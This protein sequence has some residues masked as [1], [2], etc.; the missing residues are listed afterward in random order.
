MLTALKNKV[1]VLMIG[2]QK[3]TKFLSVFLLSAFGVFVISSAAFAGTSVIATLVSEIL[4]VIVGWMGKLILLLFDLLVGRLAPY[5]DFVDSNAVST[6]W[7]LT[8]DISNMFFILILLAVAFGTILKIEQL[9]Y[10]KVLPKLLV[11]AVVINFSK[12]ICGLIIDFGQVVMLTFVNAFSAAAG[13]NFLNAF[14]LKRLL[15]ISISGAENLGTNLDWHVASAYLLAVVMMTVVLIVV[16]VFIITLAYRIVILWVLVIL[17]PLAFLAGGFPVGKASGAYSKWWEDFVGA[18][19]IGPVLAFF[20]WLAL[21]VA[22]GGNLAEAEFKEPAG[23][24][25][26]VSELTGAGALETAVGGGEN[27][28]MTEGGT[29][30]SVTSF[31]IATA[32]LLAGLTAAQSVGGVAGS[33]AGQATSGVK[34]FMGTALKGT[35][36]GAG[37]LAARAGKGA[38]GWT[39]RQTRAR[40]RL[41]GAVSRVPGM[42]KFGTDRLAGLRGQRAKGVREAAEKAR[43]LS[44]EEIQRRI[45]APALT[46]SQKEEKRALRQQVFTPGF[47][48]HLSAQGMDDNQI[49]DVQRREF[50][51]LEAE[52]RTAGDFDTMKFVGDLK[53]KSP[54]LQT[55]PD[56]RRK[57]GKELSHEDLK[58]VSLDSFKD[59]DFLRGIAERGD[60]EAGGIAKRLGGDRGKNIMQFL[61]DKP[62]GSGV[63]TADKGFKAAT[64]EAG[65]VFGKKAAA[66]LNESLVSQRNAKVDFF[67]NDGTTQKR[68]PVTGQSAR[69]FNDEVL[70][71]SMK[72]QS[73]GGN[74]NQAFG[75][76]AKQG[77]FLNDTYSAS[78]GEALKNAS[79]GASGPIKE[80]GPLD[81]GQTEAGRFYLGIDTDALKAKGKDPE[82]GNQYR[83]QVLQN[84]TVQNMVSATEV[85]EREGIPG[86]LDKVKS[87][88][89]EFQAEAKKI[90]AS[91]SVSDDEKI[92][93]D[94]IDKMMNNDTLRRSMGKK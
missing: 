77:Q 45:A 15:E 25:A 9:N 34:G 24:K 62:A 12:T 53:E 57:A 38:A 70:A 51:K 92:L 7:V 79:A 94:K 59:A 52:A 91:G 41:Y 71:D 84:I 83:D 6:G 29:T 60:K 39:D 30:G 76:D 61:K 67:T 36:L 14:G 18:V 73:H 78:W 4:N 40:E 48:K 81:E 66:V 72:I 17:S 63:Y 86:G 26:P 55:D 20:L 22:G 82:A 89:N 74:S 58:K 65:E 54:H 31:I 47:K 87:I 75:F 49:V 28:F 44:P 42:G 68:D 80:F 27:Y 32:L 10:Q 13:G 8:R 88:L 50:S 23:Y 1:V 19:V 35:A 46:A 85:A 69:V 11:M 90:Q 64:A 56:D 93:L 5:N 2:H 16:I 43:Y 3:L 37:A 21:L 33:F